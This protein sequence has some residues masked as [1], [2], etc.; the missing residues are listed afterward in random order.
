MGTSPI[1]YWTFQL[2]QVLLLSEMIDFGKD[3]NTLCFSSDVT[4]DSFGKYI[5]S[6]SS[7]QTARV[8]APMNTSVS[9]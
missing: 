5:L 6:A 7:D 1:P 4:W 3:T 2:S 9:E 8:F